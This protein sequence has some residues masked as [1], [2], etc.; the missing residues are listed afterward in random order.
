[1]NSLQ[2]YIG[3]LGDLPFSVR[4]FGDV[5]ALI[6]CQA[7]YF[8]L[9][10]A[11]EGH[12]AIRLRDVLPYIEQG[13]AALQITGDDFGNASI[14]HAAC[15]S[16]RFGNLTV[17]HYIDRIEPEH[18]LQFSAV[19]FTL[20]GQWSFIAYRGTDNTL[21]GW[22]EDCLISV[23]RTH[24]QELALQ[25]AV[26]QIMDPSI[27]YYIGGHSKGG[28]LALFATGMLP[29]SKLALLIRAYILDGPGMCEES[30][31]AD[32]LR[33]VDHKLTRIIPVFSVVGQIYAPTVTD[34][35]VIHS[36]QK[37]MLQHSLATWCTECG[38]LALAEGNDPRSLYLNETLA[39]WLRDTTTE[40]RKEC[41]T[42]LF[43]ALQEEGF[44]TVSDIA[45]PEA[46]EAVLIRLAG[47]S[48]STRHTLEDL[49]KKAV[50]GTPTIEPPAS[51]MQR[52]RSILN[53]PFVIASLLAALGIIVFFLPDYA[54]EIA[55]EAAFIFIACWSVYT[56]LR[57]LKRRKWHIYGSRE[58]III[59]IALIVLCIVLV[60][61]ESALFILGSV[62]LGA[63]GLILA[64]Q[65]GGRAMTKK[66]QPPELTLAIAEAVLAAG[67][68]IGFL[69]IPQT[70][71]FLFNKAIGIALFADSLVRCIHTIIRHRRLKHPSGTAHAHH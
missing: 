25:Y 58:R 21:T 45:G 46:F 68:G 5:D 57:R 13:Q 1:M 70:S 14:F 41:F 28:N 6:L 69:V 2:E 62:L 19:T 39:D 23:E 71:V 17:S 24:A 53:H 43:D 32:R 33:A 51:F 18:S 7:S 10:A 30:M 60:V 20:P 42:E 40:Q 63:M 52:L 50:F 4:P 11:M 12:D 44:R 22:K 29:E 26:D 35:R 16:Q 31:P 49:P 3:W 65:C 64:M 56:T 59:S 55:V 48:A 54:M 47:V 27:S 9:S 36:S 67:F 61:K 38:D 15:A 37:G 34:T 8:D 66:A